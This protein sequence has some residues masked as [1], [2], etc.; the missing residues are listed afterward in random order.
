MKN[1]PTKKEAK[2]LNRS[3]TKKNTHMVNK[4]LK[5]IDE[6]V[7]WY[8]ENNMISIF[9]TSLLGA[10]YDLAVLPYVANE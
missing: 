8:F 6:T 5:N 4:H 2:D 9:S 1:Y 7:N 3:F 10:S